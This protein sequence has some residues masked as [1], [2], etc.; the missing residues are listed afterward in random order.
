MKRDIDLVRKLLLTMEQCEHGFAPRKLEIEGYT[1]AE[2]GY[3][4]LL[5]DEAGL[6][7]ALEVT[8]S[9]DETPFAEPVRMTWAGHDFLDA[10]RD[11]GRWQKAKRI[12]DEKVKG[13]SFDI[14]KLILLEIMKE[15]V[16]RAF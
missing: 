15:Q 13:A 16:N 8:C 10:C 4:A 5:M 1:N 6:I 7:V 11:E 12:I 2:I 9:G 3:H 14:I